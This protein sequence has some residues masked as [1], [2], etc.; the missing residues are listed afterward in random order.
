VDVKHHARIHG[1]SKYGIGRTTRVFSDL[2]LMVFFQKYNVKPM[3]LFGT[4]G[5]L[6]LILGFFIE[7]YLLILKVLGEDI[8]SRPLFMVGILL[9]I[10]GVMLITTGFL[11]EIMMRT[12]YESQGKKPYVVQK[13][14]QS[15]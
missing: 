15:K 3:H 5:S 9:I 4:I 14:I 13:I 10:S 7:F 1:V 8:G 12:Y 2:M 6:S 11:S